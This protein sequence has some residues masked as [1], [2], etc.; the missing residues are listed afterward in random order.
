MAFEK[1]IHDACCDGD[2]DWVRQCI[3]DDPTSVDTDDQYNWRPIFHAG[4][5]RRLEI[6]QLLIESGADVAAHN[7]DVLHYAGEVPDNKAIVE[8]LVIHGALEAYARPTGDRS[9]QLLS[10]LFIGHEARVRSLLALHPDLANRLDGRGDH[11]IHH[12]ARNGDT[13]L[14]ALL[15]AHT[16][17]VHAR[18]QRGHTV[19]YCAAGHGHLDTVSLLLQSGADP[20]VQ[21]TDD[22]KT[23]L[24][25]LQQ[26][27]D[28][29]RFAGVAELLQAFM[30]E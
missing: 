13:D 2:L 25:W 22:G 8:L 14:V 30:S 20:R 12:A 16:A 21:F 9:R 29:S 19:L 5:H 15:I 23:I 28:D 24:E 7:G 17:D 10:A 11:P 27:P 18:N 6:V 26:Y 4:L 1:S 3:L